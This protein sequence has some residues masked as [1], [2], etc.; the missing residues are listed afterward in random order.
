MI[1]EITCFLYKMFLKEYATVVK[2]TVHKNNHNIF[3]EIVIM[4]SKEIQMNNNAARYV[5][6]IE[7]SKITFHSYRYRG[8]YL[9]L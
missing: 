9:E 7:D 2:Q 3:R 6:Y 4:S 1:P 8:L 5:F